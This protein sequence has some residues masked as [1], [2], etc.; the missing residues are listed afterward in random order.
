MTH[1][2]TPWAADGDE[3]RDATGQHIAHAIGKDGATWAEQ[4][5]NA[6]LIVRAVNAHA[7]LIA[8]LLEMA[9]MSESCECICGPES[10][11][12]HWTTCP[13]SYSVRARAALAKV[14]L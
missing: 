7:D 13:R 14:Q 5:A 6:A 8:A 2:P 10:P 1:T 4:V 11:P 3:L 9:S 12:D